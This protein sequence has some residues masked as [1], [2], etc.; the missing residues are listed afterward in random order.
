MAR[1]EKP[2][3]CPHCK[4]GYVSVGQVYDGDGY[5][6]GCNECAMQGPEV[7]SKATAIREWNKWIARGRNAPAT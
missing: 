4:P 5:T 1:R 2:L 3:P 6:C 7:R